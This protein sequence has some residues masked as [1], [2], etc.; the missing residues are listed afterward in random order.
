MW[1]N[2]QPDGHP[3]EY[4]GGASVQRRKVWL[5]P[6]TRV[7]CSNKAK[8]RKPLQFAGC[9]KLPNQSQPSLGRSLPYCEH[10]WR[11]Y[12]CLTIFFQIVDTCVSCEDIAQQSCAIVPRWQ[13]FGDFFAS[14]IFSEPH[15]ASFRPAF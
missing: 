13:I 5:T 2:A 15:A 10:V 9:P 3:A 12:C 14:C 4:I 8:M 11:R 7:L 1:A 6:T